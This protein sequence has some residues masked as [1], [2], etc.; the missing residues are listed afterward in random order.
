[1]SLSINTIH[2]DDLKEQISLHTI[3]T[4]IDIIRNAPRTTLDIIG[5]FKAAIEFQNIT[6]PDDMVAQIYSLKKVFIRVSSFY[7]HNFVKDNYI[8]HKGQLMRIASVNYHRITGVTCC[9]C[10]DVAEV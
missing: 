10:Y 5:H 4:Y 6:K 8:R 9:M 2:S 7:R 1:M 3:S